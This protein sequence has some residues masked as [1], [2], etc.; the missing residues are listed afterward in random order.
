VLG[1]LAGL[2]GG[3]VGDGR[4]S[5]LGPVPWQVALISAA[6]VAVSAGLGATAARAFGRPPRR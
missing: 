1:V 5:D 6:V 2:S 4:L 3:S